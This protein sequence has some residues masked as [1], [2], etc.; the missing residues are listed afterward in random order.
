MIAKKMTMMGSAAVAVLAMLAAPARAEE[1]HKTYAGLTLGG[2][3]VVGSNEVA[4]H[5]DNQCDAT[6]DSNG[7]VHYQNCQK[8]RF[9]LTAGAYGG[10]YISEK[11]SILAEAEGSLFPGTG[12]NDGGNLVSAGPAVRV[13]V[14]PTLWIQPGL[15]LVA[16]KP[17]TEGDVWLGPIGHFTLGVRLP[18]RGGLGLS[19]Q[20]R[21]SAT[22]LANPYEGDNSGSLVRL[23]TQIGFAW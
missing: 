7:V 2:G 1:R 12:R 9:G 23:T 10:R 18:S 14:S 6:R 11:V 22:G 16:C 13:D 20:T 8:V 4:L 3:V 21:L 19:W 17:N 5:W 15:G